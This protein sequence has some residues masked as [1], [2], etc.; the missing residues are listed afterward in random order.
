MKL[1]FN[2]AYLIGVLCAACPAQDWSAFA[3]E[4]A[5]IMAAAQP[6]S[7]EAFEPE[8]IKASSLSF[9][10]F[11]PSGPADTGAPTTVG[12]GAGTPPRS[13]AVRP[14]AIAVAST[15]G[16]RAACDPPSPFV[17]SAA[18]RRAYVDHLIRD[19]RVKYTREQLAAMPLDRLKGIHDGCHGGAE[20]LVAVPRI[21]SDVC[22]C[23][24]GKSGCTCSIAA[25][26]KAPVIVRV[27]C[28]TDAPCPGCAQMKR[29]N[30]DSDVTLD[31][32]EGPSR[33]LG[34]SPQVVAR[35][36]PVIELP[37][38]VYLHGAHSLAQIKAKI[39]TG[40]K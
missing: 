29:V 36:F 38:G 33:S 31:V 14:S 34:L 37:G 30:G 40:W 16:R 1:F 4:P 39:S 5:P 2:I 13:P 20:T 7:F 15:G 18:E 24:C 32:K 9:E 12:A 19:H 26:A 35:G 17:E 8:N 10:C 27:Y 21:V 3:P 6:L 11:E 22:P 28:M 25:A 23:G